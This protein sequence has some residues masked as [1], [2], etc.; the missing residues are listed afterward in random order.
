[1]GCSFVSHLR[2]WN[3]TN[4]RFVLFFFFM[5]K[6]NHFEVHMIVSLGV[7]D[8]E[9]LSPSFRYFFFPNLNAK[10]GI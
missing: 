8:S 9:V 7:V 6:M 1:M 10:W 2:F 5:L 3:L 4:S